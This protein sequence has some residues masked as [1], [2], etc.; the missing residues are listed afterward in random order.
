VDKV[1]AAGEVKA[2]FCPVSHLVALEAGPWRHALLSSQSGSWRRKPQGSHQELGLLLVSS[3]I[4]VIK[5]LKCHFYKIS[6]GG[7]E[8]HPLP[9]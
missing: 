9:V 1:L 8:G 6:L 5:Y 3:L 7:V 4:S 2:V